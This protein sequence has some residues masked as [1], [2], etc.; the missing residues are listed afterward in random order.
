MSLEHQ[1]WARPPGKKEAIFFAAFEQHRWQWAEKLAEFLKDKGYTEVE[2][3]LEEES[4]PDLDE[5]EEENDDEDE[6]DE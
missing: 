2:V 6:D 1:V 3:R 4:E 5:S